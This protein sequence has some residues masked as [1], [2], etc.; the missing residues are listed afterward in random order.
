MKP[1]PLHY[2]RAESVSGAVRLLT[3]SGERPVV[4]AGGQSLVPALN[5]R[6]LAPTDLVDITHVAA[7]A[8]TT[9]HRGCLFVGAAVRQAE[10]EHG[11]AARELPLLGQALELVATAEIR[12]RGTVV[13]SLVHGDPAA[14]LP[15]VLRLTG[16][17][18]HI[19]GPHSGRVVSATEFLDAPRHER[20]DPG[21]LVTA[22]EFPLLADHS[23]SAFVEE[24]PGRRIAPCAALRP[25]SPSP[26]ATVRQPWSAGQ[27][28]A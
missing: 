16:G 26:L 28:S 6:E 15:A 19:I 10:A 12:N 7:L 18:L 11:T 5:R 14:E 23:G 27:P 24:A 4:L 3:R 21:E 8:R 2:H 1:P 22:A 17:R 20:L 13:G 9:K 25:S